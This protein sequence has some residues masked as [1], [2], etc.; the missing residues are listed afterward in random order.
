MFHSE[1]VGAMQLAV[2]FG[3]SNRTQVVEV[4]AR[5]DARCTE[6][7]GRRQEPAPLSSPEALPLFLLLPQ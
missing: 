4:S 1:T 3:R 6:K 2:L 5:I 7:S